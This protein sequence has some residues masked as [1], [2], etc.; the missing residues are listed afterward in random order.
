M[1]VTLRERV[2]YKWHGGDFERERVPYKRYLIV[3]YCCDSGSTSRFFEVLHTLTLNQ[4]SDF[5]DTQYSYVEKQMV[6]TSV[7]VA[8]F[9]R[10]SQ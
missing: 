1:V 6:D 3:H 5:S 10:N 8:V 9:F 4:R 7:A 2:P